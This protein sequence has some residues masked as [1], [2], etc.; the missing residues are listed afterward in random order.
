MSILKLVEEFRKSGYL[1]DYNIQDIRFETLQYHPSRHATLS[2]FK[3][4]F[5]FS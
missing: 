2:C 5:L 4:K 3:K 1:V